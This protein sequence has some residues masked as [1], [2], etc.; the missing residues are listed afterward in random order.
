MAG[1]SSAF[2][3]IDV[4]AVTTRAM[5]FDLVEGKY[6]FIAI[7][8]SPSTYSAAFRAGSHDAVTG[9]VH[10]LTNLEDVLAL[11]FVCSDENSLIN[12]LLE[13]PEP[14][15][16]G[17]MS[18]G[19]VCVNPSILILDSAFPAQKL[20]LAGVTEK[21]VE[22][23]KPLT[24]WW[25]REKVGRVCL[26]DSITMGDRL[27]YMLRFRPD[28]LLV[29]IDPEKYAVAGDKTVFGSL[30]QTVMNEILQNDMFELLQ[31]VSL[32]SRLLPVHE[33]PVILFSG[34]ASLH[35]QLQAIFP[36]TENQIFASNGD[37]QDAS[38]HLVK[39]V[40]RYKSKTTPGFDRLETM[41]DDGLLPSA[42]A[43]KKAALFLTTPSPVE[44]NVLVV[45]ASTLDATLTIAWGDQIK[46]V[47]Y[48]PLASAVS[49]PAAPA[50][51][52]SLNAVFAQLPIADILRWSGLPLSDDQ[53]ME[54][55]SNR[56]INPG[57]IPSTPL[58]LAIDQAI[59]R[60]VM[61]RAV[62]SFTP[63]RRIGLDPSI[64]TLFFTGS[65][66]DIALDKAQ[67]MMLYLDGIQ[68][69]GISTII[70]DCFHTLPAL[71][72]ATAK[73]PAVI[74]DVLESSAYQHLGTVIS[75]VSA[76][77]TARAGAPVLRIKIDREDGVSETQDITHGSLMSLPLA[78]GQRAHL[79]L[80]PRRGVDIGM[81]GA[82]KGGKLHVV[83]GV[84][85]VVVDAR[86]R[87]V[88]LPYD[89]INSAGILRKWHEALVG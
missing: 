17:R 44:K 28:I 81:G 48:S 88:E 46:Q 6:R 75:P 49:V 10:A 24:E 11:N 77:G 74:L 89:P 80:Q 63:E 27:E 43:N 64:E 42:L 52:S 18:D 58:E 71:G 53:V 31:L 65:L 33:R 16:T 14:S 59:A 41:V 79:H 7:G 4:G 78:A 67:L 9:V 13:H 29:I 12:T 73:N 2:L 70:L 87:P 37:I 45:E 85:G 1:N 84:F 47:V 61:Q 23:L 34:V 19:G 38:S 25:C 60:L 57:N 30:K 26:E 22:S 3:V 86:G 50:A 55:V 8:K 68:P 82:G 62:S 15:P 51:D 21:S 83:G 32:A 5:F 56:F 36:G 39:A 66:V 35:S 40:S 20:L 54:Y 69:A 76:Q 72:A